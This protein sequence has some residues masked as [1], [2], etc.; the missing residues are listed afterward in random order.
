[1]DYNARHGPGF[2]RVF[3]EDRLVQVVGLRNG[4]G[5]HN[6]DGTVVN[7]RVRLIVEILEIPTTDVADSVEHQQGCE[8]IAGER[9]LFT[10]YNLT[11]ATVKDIEHL[12]VSKALPLCESTRSRA[13]IV[14]RW[15]SWLPGSVPDGSSWEAADIAARWGFRGHA[16]D[17][18]KYGGARKLP[19]P[20]AVAAKHGL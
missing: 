9:I 5:Y 13:A 2:Y 19:Q 15:V 3:A 16:R 8:A 1:M 11:P 14:N 20:A 6:D 17:L 4:L 18:V 10:A 12:L 7:P